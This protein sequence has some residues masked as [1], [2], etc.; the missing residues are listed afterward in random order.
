MMND[1]LSRQNLVEMLAKQEDIS[2]AEAKRQLDSILHLL[3]VGL[4]KHK[5]ITLVGYFQLE[6]KKRKARKG[7][8]PQT[9]EPIKI[10]A[11]KFIAFKAGKTFKDY[12]N[13]KKS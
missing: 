11:S 13:G 6:I 3:K 5:K 2:T 10:P 8:N 7:R 9:G 1:G 4:K 12:I